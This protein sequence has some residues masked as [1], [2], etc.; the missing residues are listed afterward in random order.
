MHSAAMNTAQRKQLQYFERR[1]RQAAALNRESSPK[2]FCAGVT[3]AERVKF[4]IT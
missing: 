2:L 3:I 4:W 1:G